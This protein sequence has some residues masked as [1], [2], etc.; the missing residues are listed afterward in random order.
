M[1]AFGSDS[2][3]AV[4]GLGSIDTYALVK[5]DDEFLLTTTGALMASTDGTVWTKR[6]SDAIF[7]KPV[8]V[9]VAAAAA[10][11]MF[12][13]VDG[14]LEYSDDSGATWT[15][16]LVTGTVAAVQAAGANVMVQTSTG[17]VRSDNY[18]NT[19]HAVD[20]GGTA[21]AFAI[22]SDHV[23]AGIGTGL[24]V[25][26]D[27]GATW[28]TSGDGLPVGSAVNQLFLSGAALVASTG[29]SV[30]VAQIQ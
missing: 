4:A 13:L 28:S 2:F 23:Y 7:A 29:G 19:F 25:S 12:A 9:L 10:T 3:V 22:S 30:Y 5:K 14:A 16:G 15:T 6:S 8:S 26:S 24:R 27:G 17:T 11:R 18:G 20:I 21:Q 1:L